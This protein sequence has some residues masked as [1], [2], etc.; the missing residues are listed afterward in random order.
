MPDQLILAASHKSPQNVAVPDMPLDLTGQLAKDLLDLTARLGARARTRIRSAIRCCWCRWPSPGAWIPATLTEADIAALIRHLRDAAFADRARRLAAYVG[1]IDTAAERRR[2]WPAWRSICCGP[3][4][5]TARCAGP[6]TA[7]WSRRTRFAAVFT[8]HPTFSL[9]LPSRPAPWPRPPAARPAAGLRI[10][11][12]AAD[13]AAQTSSTRPPPP[14]PTAATRSTGS[15]R[16]CCRSPAA[17]GRTAGPSSTPR[18]VILSTWVGYDT[19][20]RTDIGWWDTLRLRLEM[21]RLQLARLHGQVA[22][23]GRAP[24]ALRGARSPRREARS[25]AQIAAVPGRSRTRR[26][27]P[28]S[29]TR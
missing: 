9:P 20:G 27:S 25:T 12:P 19:D 10:A 22:A 7:R 26:R 28:P 4:R 8:A 24:S 11:P 16:R 15:T 2:R 6:S 3:T 1:G 29:R 23:A 5:T 14:S 21:K 13:H 17:P 18:P